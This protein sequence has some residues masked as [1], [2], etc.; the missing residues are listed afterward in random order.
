MPPF[1]TA[2]LGD[3]VLDGDA[4][5][6]KKQVVMTGVLASGVAQEVETAAAPGA[7]LSANAVAKQR[8]STVMLGFVPIFPTNFL[9]VLII[10]R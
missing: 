10:I 8:A 2:D 1:N 6:S 9:T 3:S 7:K 5:R 4:V